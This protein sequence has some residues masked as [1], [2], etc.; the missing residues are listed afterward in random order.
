MTLNS[1]AALCASVIL[2]ALL[3]MA[4][5]SAQAATITYGDYNRPT[6]FEGIDLDGTMYD[7]TVI[8]YVAYD[9]VYTSGDPLFMGDEP[10]AEVARLALSNALIDDEY[11]TTTRIS[12]LNVPYAIPSTVYSAGINLTNGPD[13]FLLVSNQTYIAYENTGFTVWESSP[14]PLPAAVWL[15]GAG[16]I[17]LAGLKRKFL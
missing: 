15:L 14:V 17:G 9:D 8:W 6:L 3:F 7:V 13:R 16:L 5:L 1:R 12:Y 10:G 4:P 11:G 2:T